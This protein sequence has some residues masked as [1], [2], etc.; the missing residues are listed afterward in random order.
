M[1]L[2]LGHEF[3]GVVTAVGADVTDIREGDKVAVEPIYR[4]GDCRP[5][6]T[7]SRNV[8]RCVG[9]HGL[10]ADG[11][12]ADYTVVER[13]MVHKLPDGVPVEIGAL[14]EPMSVAYPA[15]KLG[16]VNDQSRALIFG[17]GP[18]GLGLRFA[19]RGIG[20]TEIDIVEPSAARRQA[21]DALGA[22]TIDP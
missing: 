19:L 10:M 3:S 22:R 7:G 16:N 13:N 20:L 2:V 1:P 9:F 15:A 17:A 18:I 8:C 6:R 5:C 14:V 4:C 11:G 21:V 12:M